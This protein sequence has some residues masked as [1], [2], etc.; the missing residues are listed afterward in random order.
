MLTDLNSNLEKYEKA[1]AKRDVE[2][3]SYEMKEIAAIRS[4]LV[5]EYKPLEH[6]AW[7][8]LVKKGKWTEKK[9]LSD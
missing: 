9:N 7:W 3:D 2:P 6:D 5:E 8:K 4:S 1:R